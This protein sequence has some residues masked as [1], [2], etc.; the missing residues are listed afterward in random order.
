MDTTVLNPVISP[1]A[2]GGQF[3]LNSVVILCSSKHSTDTKIFTD[4]NE[5]FRNSALPYHSYSL[6]TGG[7]PE[8][9]THTKMVKKCGVKTNSG[10]QK[11][12]IL[13]IHA[14]PQFKNSSLL[15][16]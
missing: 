12:Y 4:A 6:K 7:V 16:L 14:A 8:G 10:G 9:I 3:R 5:F 2:G 1:K 13:T 11:S 15:R